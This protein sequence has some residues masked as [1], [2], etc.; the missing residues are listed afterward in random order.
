M[1]LTDKITN[2]ADAI[3]SKTGKTNKLTLAEMPNEIEGIETGTAPVLQDKTIE[4]TENGTTNIKADNNYDGLNNVSVSV[5]VETDEGITK[6]FT[7]DTLVENGGSI[8]D[9][10]YYNSNGTWTSNSSYT[11]WKIP[12]IPGTTVYQQSASLTFYYKNIANSGDTIVYKYPTLVNQ[13]SYDVPVAIPIPY[14]ENYAYMYTCWSKTDLSNTSKPAKLYYTTKSMMLQEKEVEITNNGTITIRPDAGY[15][16]LKN[17]TLK[18]NVAGGE[19]PPTEYIQDGLIAWFD[20]EDTPVGNVNWYS[21]VGSDRIFETTNLA[22][23]HDTT[24][25]CY[26]NNKTLSM[27]TSADYYKEGYTIEAVGGI[28]SAGN[29]GGSYGGWLITMNETGS[30]GIGIT[31]STGDINFVNNGDTLDYK[32]KGYYDKTFGASLYLEDIVARGVN[33]ICKGK[34]SLNGCNWLDFEE[35]KPASSLAYSN[36]PILGYYIPSSTSKGSYM[37]YGYVNCIRI[38]NRQLTNE[39]IAHN[40][41]IDKARFNITE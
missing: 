19:A 40:H 3:R 18:I 7:V 27:L 41:A 16:A 35:T 37:S 32:F 25:K 2:I 23:M 17:I 9:N 34:A 38:Y 36:H 39:E 26:R 4:I 10:G 15:N 8:I 1:A 11:T 13:T 12:I 20:G 14:N 30:M 21:K 31:E 6:M 24:N 5:N 28:E 22:L 33:Q 29:T